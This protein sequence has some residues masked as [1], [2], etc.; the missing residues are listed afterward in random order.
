[1]S[2]DDFISWVCDPA[3]TNDELFTVELL[4]DQAR[5]GLEWPTTVDKSFDAR[6]ER[7]KARRQNPAYRPSLPREELEALAARSAAVPAFSGGGL[8]DRSVRDLAA[9]RFF[10]ALTNLSVSGSDVSDLSPVAELAELSYFSIGEHG[11]L[12]GHHALVMAQCGAMPKLERVHLALRHPWPDLRAVADWRALKDVNFSGNILAWE[13]VQALPT[14]RSVALKKWVGGSVPL[15]DLA[16]LPEMPAVRILTIHETSSLDGVE[17]YPTVLNLEVGGIFRDLSPLT[18]LEK[19]T[20]LTLQGE[21]F[22]DLSPL[23]RMPGL[24]QLRLIRE[25]AIDLSALADC[26]HLRRVEMER[27]AMMRTEVAALNAGLIPEA[28]DF[29]TPESRPLGEPRFYKIAKDDEAAEAFFQARREKAEHRRE[30]FFDGDEA[31]QKAEERYLAESLQRDLDAM[32]GRGWGLLTSAWMISLKRY[33]DTMRVLEV[34]QLLR[35][36]SARMRLPRKFMLN[37]EPH[38]DMS[39]ELEQMQER[40]R[41]EAEPEGDWLAKYHEPEQ[42]LAENEEQRQMREERYQLLEREHLH[43]IRGEEG[44]DPDL[45]ELLREEAE[46]TDEA[47]DEEEEPLTPATNEDDEG[48]GGVAI[49][50]PPP[51]PPE[52]ESLGEELQFYVEVHEDCVVANSRWVDCASYQLDRTFEEWKPENAA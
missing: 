30:A 1:M 37:V 41:K 51:A 23:A 39:Y 2:K 47:E 21:L 29:E 43:Q 22:H 15:R 16:K 9:L 45:I 36:T 20:A 52:T 33:A 28:E 8:V 50:P 40:D 12:G 42:V 7:M 49:A 25:R 17:R 10:P 6:M 24:R 26:P 46:P 27:C 18:R 19:V 35:E 32:L 4:L 13:E 38:G 11:D 44:V 31:M 5:L 3:R 14:V 34:I 48:E